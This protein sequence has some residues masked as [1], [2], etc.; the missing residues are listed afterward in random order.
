MPRDELV[1]RLEPADAYHVW[2]LCPDVSWISGTWGGPAGLAASGHAWGAFAEGR[3]VSVACT[4]FVG[5]LYE[6]IGS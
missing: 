1:R 2:G 4:F 6:D 5:H 3:L